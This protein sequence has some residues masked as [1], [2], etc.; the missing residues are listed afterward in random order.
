MDPDRRIDVSWDDGA[1][2]ARPVT[3]R[4]TT[5]DRAGLWPDLADLYQCIRQHLE[6]I[7]KWSAKTVL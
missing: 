3:V 5:E 2:I 4:V 1:S 7:A 6:G